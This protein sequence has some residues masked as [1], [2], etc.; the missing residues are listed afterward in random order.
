ALPLL[1]LMNA[2]VVFLALYVMYDSET[3][4]L[5]WYALALA[6]AYLLLSSQFKRRVGS[7][8]EVVKTINLLHV[9]IAIAFIT[10]AVPLKL[11]AHWITIGWLVQSAVPPLVSVP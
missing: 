11:N 2:A 8:P 6:A 1:P 10:I 5:T 3:V 9:A 4:R 7:E